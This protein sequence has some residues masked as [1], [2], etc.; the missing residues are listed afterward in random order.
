VLTYDEDF[1]GRMQEMWV[2]ETSTE[3][4]KQSLR[5][6]AVVECL[7]SLKVVPERVIDESVRVKLK[8]QWRPK[9]VRDACN[10]ENLSKKVTGREQSHSKR[11]A[12]WATASK[13]ISTPQV[14]WSSYP[15]PC[16]LDAGYGTIRLMFPHWV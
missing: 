14:L 6:Q 2:T 1:A 5:G 3:I 15:I 10:V 13:A 16:A 7:V 4:S 9:E 8:L 12:A 11:E